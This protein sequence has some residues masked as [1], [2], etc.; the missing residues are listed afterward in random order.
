MSDSSFSAFSTLSILGKY[1]A[2]SWPIF[3]P[4][5]Y[6]TALALPRAISSNDRMI[7]EFNTIRPCN[8]SS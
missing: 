4:A 7:I 1:L 5:R 2:V 8:A 3:I 6:T